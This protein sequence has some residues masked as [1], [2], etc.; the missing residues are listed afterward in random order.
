MRLPGACFVAALA[1]FAAGCGGGDD[2][3]TVFAAAS[4]TDVF[5]RLE[6]DARF[7]FA[8]SDELA[9]QL[10][11]GARADVYAAANVAYP[12]E[13]HA[14]GL[15]ARPHVFATNKLVLIVPRDNPARI[16]AV[17]D[18]A[19]EGVKLVVGAQGVPIG[20]YTREVLVKL[21]QRRVL[22]GV[23]SEEQ[24][25]KGVVSKVAQGEADAG[26]VYRTDVRTAAGDVRLIT[27]PA[28]AQAQVEY[29]AAVVSDTRRRD[30]AEDFLAGLLDRNGR[31]E[32]RRAGFGVP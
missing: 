3:L 13:L 2:G 22:R 5:L 16:R 24:D 18:L 11:E 19:R 29:A 20:D 26:F 12:A 21:G 6:G 4:L 7:N 30:E 14:E 9:T 10:R 25:V 28:R 8:G 31:R 17:G 23:V 15:L 1:L 27:L 32:L